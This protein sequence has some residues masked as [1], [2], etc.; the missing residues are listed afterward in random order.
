MRDRRLTGETGLG[1]AGEVEEQRARCL[2]R[3]LH[4]H[5]RALLLQPDVLVR[6]AVGDR[7]AGA[8]RG[9]LREPRAVEV[10]TGSDRKPTL[11]LPTRRTCPARSTPRSTKVCVV[12]LGVLLT[13]GLAPVRPLVP[14]RL[15]SND[16]MSGDVEVP[17]PGPGSTRATRARRSSSDVGS[18]ACHC[19][20]LP[21]RALASPSSDESAVRCRCSCRAR[22]SE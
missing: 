10:P 21:V 19:S 5:R 12:R 20:P 3:L 15:E 8:G 9:P 2:Q 6:G 16:A 4:G 18:R 13:A 11:S 17:V 1:L 14:V 22:S 7:D